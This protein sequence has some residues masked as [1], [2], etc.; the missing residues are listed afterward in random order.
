MNK[1]KKSLQLNQVANLGHESQGLRWLQ[2]DWDEKRE[3]ERGQ[4]MMGKA[5]NDPKERE[6]YSLD[7]GD[8]LKGFKTESNI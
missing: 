7:S 5:W 3:R 4:I 2:A 6:F 1:R 8:L